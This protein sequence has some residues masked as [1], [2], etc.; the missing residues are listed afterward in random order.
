MWIDIHVQSHTHKQTN[1]TKHNPLWIR[2]SCDV[3]LFTADNPSILTNS[4]SSSSTDP[5][6]SSSFT[7]QLI[8]SVEELILALP[9]IADPVGFGLRLGVGYSSCEQLIINHASDI[10]AQ[11][12]AIAAEW[13]RQSPHSTW[14]KVVEALHNHGLVHD[15]VHLASKVGVKSP[16][17]QEDGDSDHQ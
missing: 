15:A 6:S 8:P 1:T 16:V 9:R 3:Y 10:N 14:N 12:R 4:S 5:A 17:S 2:A 7:N 11:V 13:Y